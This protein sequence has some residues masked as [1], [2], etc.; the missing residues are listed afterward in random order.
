MRI[1]LAF[2]F[3]AQLALNEEL[4]EFFIPGAIDDQHQSWMPDLY[5]MSR[6][7]GL[8]ESNPYPQLGRL[9]RYR[10]AKAA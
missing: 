9:L 8:W 7:S 10:Y 6:W 3:V 4:C 2:A 1:G 5:G